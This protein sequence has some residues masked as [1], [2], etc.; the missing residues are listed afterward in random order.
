[1]VKEPPTPVANAPVLSS[2]KAI[3]QISDRGLSI[4]SDRFD[5]D[6]FGSWIG[7]SG[8]HALVPILCAVL[9]GFADVVWIALNKCEGN[10]GLSIIYHFLYRFYRFLLL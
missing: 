6:G 5:G 3:A 9:D 10:R 1:M 7:S 2:F 8:I 4:I